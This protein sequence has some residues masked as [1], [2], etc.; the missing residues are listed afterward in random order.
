MDKGINRDIPPKNK[1]A[2]IVKSDQQNVDNSLLTIFHKIIRGVST[3]SKELVCHLLLY[4]P[5][6]LHLTEHHLSMILGNC[7][8]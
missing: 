7:P 2:N 8:T 1:A 6:I 5:Q 4:W 3:K